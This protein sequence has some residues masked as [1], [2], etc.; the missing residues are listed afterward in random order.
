[1]FTA[2]DDAYIEAK[3]RVDSALHLLAARRGNLP[4][5]ERE[6][7]QRLIEAI[8]TALWAFYRFETSHRSYRVTRPDRYV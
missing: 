7:I 8:D 6:G 3:R 4:D 2:N 5:S 1:M